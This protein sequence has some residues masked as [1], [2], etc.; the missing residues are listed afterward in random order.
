[1][2][3]GTILGASFRVL[4][5]NPRPVVGFSLLVHLVIAIVSV[6]TIGRAVTTL[7]A[8]LG[9]LA[10]GNAGSSSQVGGLLLAE[11]ATFGIA[12]LGLVGSSILQ[13]IVAV[14]VARGTVGERL[15]LGGLWRRARG[16]VLVLVGWSLAMVAALIVFG[17]IVIVLIALVAG[18]VGAASARN[19]NSG[20][21]VGVAILVGILLFLGGVVVVVW[22]GIKVSLVPSALVIERLTLRKAIGRSW[23]LTRRFF[24]RTFGIELLVAVILAVAGQIVQTP[25]SVVIGLIVVA[26]NP[27]GAGIGSITASLQATQIASTVVDAIVG[28]V[29]GVVSAAATALIY[30]DLR[31]RKEG[32]D[33]SL[34]RFV[35]ARQAG[36]SDVADP[37]TAGVAA[38]PPAA[39]PAGPFSA[40]PPASP[41]P[42]GPFPPA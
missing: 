10:A 40:G 39:F 24:W 17:V 7:G 33:L 18:L 12:A 30:L 5:R 27:T 13:G 20:A 42:A 35:D 11:F 15:T 38:P 3:L 4:R 1:M 37:Y 9:S 36:R 8:A 6:F 23:T 29:T 22:I 41:F 26:G 19:G 34:M 16:R 25:V 14:E 21:G 2:T 32:L 31:I 28:T